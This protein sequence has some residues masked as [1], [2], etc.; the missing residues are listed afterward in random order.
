MAGRALHPLT[1]FFEFN[2]YF[3]IHCRAIKNTQKGTLYVAAAADRGDRYNSF[4]ASR[5]HAMGASLFVAK[6]TAATFQYRHP[7]GVLDSLGEID[8]A[9]H[10]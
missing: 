2:L 7:R 8:F 3:W 10:R 6:A 9:I 4:L 1:E 5:A